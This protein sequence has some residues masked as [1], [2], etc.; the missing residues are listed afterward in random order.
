MRCTY[1]VRRIAPA[2]VDIKEGVIV[3]RRLRVALAIISV[4]LILVSALALAYALWPTD[5]N[6]AREQQ[7]IAPTALVA[8]P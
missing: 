2:Y 7:R 3:S 8:P 6:V 5:G 4:T 1:R